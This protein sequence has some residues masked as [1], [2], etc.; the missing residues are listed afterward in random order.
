MVSIF[1]SSIGFPGI[2]AFLPKTS[3]SSAY[4]C[5]HIIPKI[6]EAL[7][8]DLAQ[9]PRKLMLQMDH[10]SPH[11]ART[12]LEC[13]KKFRIRSIDHPPYSPDLAPSDFH[14]FGK[15]K[16]T[17]AGREFASTE[18]LLWAIREITGL[19]ERDQLESVVDAW[20]RRLI[21][22]IATQGEYVS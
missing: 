12:S 20:E 14:L 21:Q 22:C 17:F 19:I 7:P 13:L 8:F 11:P 15:L 18:E 16:G 2:T 4:F 5:D 6:V 1:W 10:A 9:S 3:F